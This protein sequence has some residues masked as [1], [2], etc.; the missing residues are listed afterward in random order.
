M[1]VAGSQFPPEYRGTLFM[2]QHGSW[3]RA[4]PIGYRVMYATIDPSGNTTSYSVFAEGWQQATSED[5]WGGHLPLPCLCSRTS[6]TC[7]AGW[8]A[9]LTPAL[10]ATCQSVVHLALLLPS[11]RLLLQ[12]KSGPACQSSAA[13]LLH[14]RPCTQL[15]DQCTQEPHTHRCYHHH[16]RTDS[17]ACSVGRPVDV[18][19]LTDGSLLVSD[20]GAGVVYRVRYDSSVG[21][22]AAG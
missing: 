14:H 7:G 2:A 5:P 6:T 1:A 21:T 10:L 15:I 22:A 8:E 11:E 9:R 19:P 17:C 12:C 13:A 16:P 4:E 18:L 20:D 3:N